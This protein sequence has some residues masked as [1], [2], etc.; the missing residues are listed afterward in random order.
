[1]ALS[2]EK[3]EAVRFGDLEAMPRMTQ[4]RRMRV[5]SLKLNAGDLDHAYSVLADCFDEKSEEIK[6]FMAK[7]M[8]VLEL[9]RLQA[10]LLG[11]E[12]GLREL[13]RKTELLMDKQVD[14][15]YEKIKSQQSAEA[16]NV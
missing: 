13:D 15:A 16:T 9:T 3:I 6:T 10:Y 5:G 14:D 2:F 4:E 1:M 12:A 7:N 8:P 11:G